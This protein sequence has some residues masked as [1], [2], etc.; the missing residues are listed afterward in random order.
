MGRLRRSR[1]ASPSGA[2]ATWY[3]VVNFGVDVG[4]K[5]ILASSAHP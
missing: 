4:G 2:W 3:Y 1:A 5:A